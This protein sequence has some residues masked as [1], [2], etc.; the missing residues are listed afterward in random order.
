[1]DSDT[2]SGIFDIVRFLTECEPYSVRP[3]RPPACARI[4]SNRIRGRVDTVQGRWYCARVTDRI[5]T[6]AISNSDSKSNV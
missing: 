4:L 1:M 2:G 5:R 3:H 6:Y